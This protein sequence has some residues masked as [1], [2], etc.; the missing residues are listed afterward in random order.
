MNMVGINR[1]KSRHLLIGCDD[2]SVRHG[3]VRQRRGGPSTITYIHTYI[4][5]LMRDEKEGRKKEAS[6]VKQTNKAKQH[7]TPKAVTCPKKNE[8][9]QVGLEPT[10]LYTLH[11]TLYTLHSRQSALPL[12]YQ[13]SSAGWAQISHLI[14]DLMNR[15]TINSHTCNILWL[16]SQHCTAS[17]CCNYIPECNCG[18]NK[19][20]T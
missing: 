14:V 7:S 10:T 11:S 17:H 5:V 2:V 19:F 18:M 9:P 3:R 20:K 13:G 6:K 4:H 16:T 1:R 8:L 15:L 12:S